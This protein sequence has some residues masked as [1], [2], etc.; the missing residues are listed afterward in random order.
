MAQRETKIDSIRTIFSSC[1]PEGWAD[2]IVVIEGKE[3][4]AIANY[5]EAIRDFEARVLYSFIQSLLSGEYIV[6][7]VLRQRIDEI[8]VLIEQDLP[9]NESGVKAQIIRDASLKIE[10]L[11]YSLKR[12]KRF[13]DS[14]NNQY[15]FSQRQY[16][17]NAYRRK[18]HPEEQNE[19]SSVYNI[20]FSVVETDH[21]LSYD[22]ILLRDLILHHT[23]LNQLIR[24]NAFP[25]SLLP[26]IKALD[27][28]CLFLLKKL[29]I[30]DK[31]GV[32]YMLD[33]EYTHLEMDDIKQGWLDD[34]ENL[35]EFYRADDTS[36]HPLGLKLDD[37]S[38]KSVIRV[39]HY[40]LLI[41]Y[42]K[43]SPKVKLSQID[44]ILTEFNEKYNLLL[45]YYNGRPYDRYALN[46]LKSYMYNSRLTF[47][48]KHKCSFEELVSDMDQIETIQSEMHV[49]DYYPFMCAAEYLGDS[50]EKSEK[51]I[52]IERERD[53]LRK[54]E[55]YIDRFSSSLSICEQQS[56]Y[57]LQ[58][59]YNDCLVR[60]EDVDLGPVFFASS[61][62]RPVQY[63]LIQERLDAIKSKGILC[64][65]VLSLREEKSEIESIKKS[66]D[67]SKK[68]TIEI[69]SA[70][71]AIITFLFGTIDFFSNTKVSS[72][73]NQI[74][75]I[76]SL[77]IILLVF[78][79]GVAILTIRHEETFCAYLKQPRMWISTVSLLIFT[80]LL[81]YLLLNVGAAP[82]LLDTSDYLLRD[83]NP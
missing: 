56:F 46:T 77:G 73:H 29:L 82:E 65:N 32:D 37:R 59:L 2:R 27:G 14:I 50:I 44:K 55:E 40:P 54:L 6:R 10:Y 47:R 57:P 41:K 51:D 3:D 23:Y 52:K 20:L 28:K 63:S 17:I 79:S 80:G 22:N 45:G 74:F 18:G 8:Q 70:F 31:T 42:Y 75:S 66:I 30:Y 38:F 83:I 67:Q 12:Y 48:I 15:S 72:F 35:F 68:Q 39:S 69:I 53:M 71:T 1:F 43:D 26:A 81:V 11:D 62:F 19:F 13:I 34:L 16:V 76:V 33:F 36:N 61:Y 49:V 24:E 78:I 21:R 7:S 5:K 4:E 25:D 60:Y 58:S 64:R 9:A